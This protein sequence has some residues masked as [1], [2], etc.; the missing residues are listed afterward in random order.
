MI[1]WHSRG[2]GMARGGEGD[3]RCGRGTRGKLDKGSVREPRAAP[4]ES[5]S[6]TAPGADATS[7]RLRATPAGARSTAARGRRPTRAARM[8]SGAARALARARA[9]RLRPAPPPPA[10]PAPAHSTFGVVNF[11]GCVSL[12]D[13]SPLTPAPRRGGRAGCASSSAGAASSTAARRLASAPRRAALRTTCDRPPSAPRRAAGGA[14]GP[15]LG[16]AGDPASLGG[17]SREKRAPTVTR[18]SPPAASR[19]AAA[20]ASALASSTTTCPRALRVTRAHTHRRGA[21][22]GGEGGAG[23]PRAGGFEATL[24]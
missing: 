14:L 21:G 19:A 16:C 5:S 7:H 13:V 20:V 6:A 12:R 23:V 17:A 1:A 2:L 10:A 24:G 8:R 4:K 11:W 9:S 3:A 18:G 22:R 15:L